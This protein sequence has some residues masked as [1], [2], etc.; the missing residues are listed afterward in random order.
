MDSFPEKELAVRD[1]R[2][3]TGVKAIDNQL[4]FGLDGDA[5]ADLDIATAAREALDRDRM[6]PHG[7]VQVIVTD[8]WVALTGEVRHHFQIQ[9]AHHAVGRAP[10]V[11]DVVN[12]LTLV[13]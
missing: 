9:A 11:R 8:G 7:S 6:V 10:G 1:A 13:D 4:V 2:Y 5:I 3:A 12:N